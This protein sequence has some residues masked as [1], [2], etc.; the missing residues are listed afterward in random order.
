MDQ[1]LQILGAMLILAGFVATQLRILVQD[2]YVYLLLNLFG[3]AILGVVAF[4][5]QQWGFV[6][7]EC[8]WGL[9][10]LWGILVRIRKG[11]VDRD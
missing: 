7:L 3:C 10:S 11:P 8:A 1:W 6:L 2:S 4:A 9:V 5:G